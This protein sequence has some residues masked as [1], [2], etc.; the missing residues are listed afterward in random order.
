[1]RWA[2]D[3]SVTLV[4][5]ATATLKENPVMATPKAVDAAGGCSVSVITIVK[6]ERPT[7]SE[8]AN[9]EYRNDG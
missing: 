5:T 2:R 1:M 8:Y 7:A 9:A 3:K 4:I 6:V